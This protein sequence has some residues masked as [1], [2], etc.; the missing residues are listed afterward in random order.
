MSHALAGCLGPQAVLE[1]LVD[2]EVNWGQCNLDKTHWPD[3]DQAWPDLEEGSPG[4]GSRG[5]KRHDGRE[6]MAYCFL[7]LTLSM[8]SSQMPFCWMSSRWA[9]QTSGQNWR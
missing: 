7:P 8:P 9:A 1:V 2:Q 3:S 6:H 5:K 4:D